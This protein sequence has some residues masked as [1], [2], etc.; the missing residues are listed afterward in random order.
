MDDKDRILT[1]NRRSFLRTT[2]A[3]VVGSG[4]LGTAAA[5]GIEDQYRSVIDV[6]D[7]GADTT[8]EQSVS[9]VLQGLV[10]DETLLKFPEGRYFMDEQVRF[11]DF[12]NFGM[13]GDDATLVPADYKTFDGPQERLFRLGTMDRPGRDVLVEN[14][15]VDQRAAQ[16]GIRAFEVTVSDGL[17]VRDVDIVGYHDSGTWGPGLFRIVDSDGSGQ[18]ERFRAP[19]GGAWETEAPGNLWRGPTGILANN[20][21]GHLRFKDC[22]VDD[23]P[24]NGLYATGSGSIEVIG[25]KYHNSGTVN[26]RLDT[27][28]GSIHGAEFV[29]DESSWYHD[30]QVPIRVQDGNWFDI[31]NV[32]IDLER[33]N[34]DAIQFKSG[35]GGG[36]VGNSEIT[37]RNEPASGVLVAPSAG[38]TYL[39][40]VDVDMDSSGNAVR[41]L[42]DDP[43][44]VIVQGGRISGE[45][46]GTAL[47]NA[48]RCE[49]DNCEFRDITMDQWGDGKR[50]GLALTGESSIVY[51][52]EFRVN[53]RP[54]TAIGDDI[55]IQG[56][57][58]NSYSAQESVL[59]AGSAGSV[60][61][62]NNGLPDG[63]T[64]NGAREV[65]TTGTTY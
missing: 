25:G 13:V 31:Q 18:V 60:R 50:S 64:D 49:R 9:A 53:H 56:C 12:E 5:T 34:G 19:D 46:P 22:V 42:G 29:V 28:T 17:T 10:D 63:I 4:L 55:W 51:D 11:T 44:E 38:Q 16:T 14:F 36:Y 3:S 59:L 21:D 30:S 47:R 24:D 32:S 6:A 61:L 43:G 54:I 20:N 7:A 62:K 58:L 57:Y 33:P 26:V 23:F 2:A 37:I 27:D 39:E 41:I 15:T 45:A 35:A 52:C 48:I 40:D 1:D 8:G 65:V